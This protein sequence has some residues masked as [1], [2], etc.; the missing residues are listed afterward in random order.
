M[1]KIMS[2]VGSAVDIFG[3]VLLFYHSLEKFPDPQWAG[4]FA[5]EGESKE[6]RGSLERTSTKKETEG[7]TLGLVWPAR[8]CTSSRGTS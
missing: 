2:I 3:V 4:F 5:V 6:L 7:W 1:P 8:Y